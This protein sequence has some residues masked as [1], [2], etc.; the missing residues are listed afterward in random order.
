MKDSTLIIRYANW[1]ISHPWITILASILLVMG[2][3]SGGKYLAFKTDYRVFFSADNPQLLAF[4]ELEASYTKNDNVMFILAPKSG[5]AF[6]EQ[7]LS[8]I[9]ELTEKAWQVP[10]SIRVDSLSNFQHTEANEDD[11]VVRDLI[12]EEITLDED[13]RSSIKKVALSEPVLLN[14]LIPD[15]SHVT[16]V[17]VTIQLPG[18]SL[19]EVPET[20]AFSRNLAAE[21]KANYPDIKIYLSG[22]VFMNNAF[23][24]ASQSD[25]QSLV[26]IS[27]ALM[28][29][30][31]GL[32]LRGFTGTVGTLFVILF[33]I[34]A[35]MGFGGHLG[36]PI[37][38][39]S[40][41]TPTI[42]LTI[43]IANCVHILVTMLHEMRLG[44]EK[45]EAIVESLRVN[46]QPVSLA[47]LTTAIGFLSML[48]A[49]VPPF[50][51]LGV[52]TSAGVVVSFILS[53]TFLPAFMSIF[54]VKVKLQKAD[55]S[56]F[57]ISLGD[58]V[59]AKKR[60][61]M[62]TMGIIVI[63][64]A[65]SVTRNELNDVFVHYFDKTVSF[66]NDADF[67]TENLSG[68]YIIDYS[69][70]SGE[71]GGI[72]NPGFLKDV[73]AFSEWYRAQPETIH[74]NTLSDI[75]KRL[76]KNL[77]GDDP[78]WYRLPD[79]RDLSAQYLLLYEMSLPYGLD[80]N[81]QINVEKS[82][83]RFTATLET[84]STNDLLALEKRADKWI[85]AN[86]THF[87]KAESSGTSVM[88]AHIGKRNI[89]S[90][91]MGTTL[92]LIGISI[93][94]IFALRSLR[95]GLISMIPNLVP[96][97]MGFG[98]WGLLVGEIGL[99]LSIVAGMTLGIVVDDS[100]Q[101]ASWC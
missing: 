37:T 47:S 22:M 72:S 32:M 85:K 48:F 71:P 75:M 20:V 39:P 55:D 64:L 9:R 27:F 98:L 14:R 77:H 76:N 15:R 10:Y 38:P 42:I 94:L 101:P 30:T 99:G 65:S 49:D 35:G 63:V 73:A 52:M 23:S 96:A 28:L 56:H 92:A 8:A 97:A 66:R 13:T 4:E 82:A 59:V 88:F 6:D 44:R 80:L 12:S 1:V 25:M 83:T 18:E 41:S 11:L 74:V 84:M 67:M 5:N 19:T 62:L 34:L 3:A 36:F 90:M 31:L 69:L 79:E 95:I 43:A 60:V 81:N 58:F 54:P 46:M 86:T 93:I 87:A 100:V 53:V 26:P 33:S 40:A 61:L 70:D 50:H 57:M 17:N 7:T 21:I 89:I 29:V 91:L 51:H 2:F 45:K 68:L 16:G 78:E 24:E